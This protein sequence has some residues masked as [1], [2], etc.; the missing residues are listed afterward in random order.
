MS[1]LLNPAIS[2]PSV[3]P[4]QPDG[5]WEELSYGRGLLGAGVL[6]ESWKGFVPPLYVHVLEA[7]GSASGPHRFRRAESR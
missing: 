4:Y 2:G 3:Y 5:L 1:G 7:D 6:T